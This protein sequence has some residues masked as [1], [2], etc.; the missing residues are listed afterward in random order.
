MNKDFEAIYKQ[1]C[2]FEPTAYE[3]ILSHLLGKDYNDRD[4]AIVVA[5]LSGIMYSQEEAKGGR[6]NG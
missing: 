4:E 2:D 5:F 6:L 3:G 1:A